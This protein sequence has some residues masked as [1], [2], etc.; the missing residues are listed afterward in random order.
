[1]SQDTLLGWSQVKK[2]IL[3]TDGASSGNP[4]DSGIGV[5]IRTEGEKI[6][7]SEYIGMATNNVAEY[8]ALL[9]GLLKAKKLGL[10]MVDVFLDSEL[11]VKQIRGEYRVKSDSLMG[12][13]NKVMSLLKTFKAYSIKHVPREEN[14]EADRLAKK[15]IKN[16]SKGSLHYALTNER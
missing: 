12:L 1:M 11:L 3:Y 16:R 8:T 15:A 7:L 6:E 14:T 10:D 13:Y 2:G 9:T 4:G 5:V